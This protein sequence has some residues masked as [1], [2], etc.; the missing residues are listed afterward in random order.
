MLDG[1]ACSDSLPC[2]HGLSC[3]TDNLCHP[4]PTPAPGASCKRHVGT[5][6]ETCNAWCVFP[7]PDAA[8]GTCGAPVVPGPTPCSRL[9]GSGVLGCAFGSFIDATP[10]TNADAI[11]DNC[12]CQPRRPLGGACTTFVQCAAGRCVNSKCTALLEAGATCTGAP[13][14]CKGYCDSETTHKC[15][16]PAVCSP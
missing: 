7:T 1:K 11:S 10:A 4:D 8:T 6:G 12:T 14:E 3:G 9:G 13:G 16:G 2:L 5:G 15:I